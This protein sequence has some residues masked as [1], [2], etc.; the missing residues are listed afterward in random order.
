MAGSLSGVASQQ[1][2]PIQNTFQPGGTAQQARIQEREQEE[3][4][5]TRSTAVESGQSARA[6]NER[7]E[8][9]EAVQSRRDDSIQLSGS[10]GRGGVIDLTV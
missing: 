1:Q 7:D 9:R 3:R 8:Q 6:N 4:Q 5:V 2:A 10:Q